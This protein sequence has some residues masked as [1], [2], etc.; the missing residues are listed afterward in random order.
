M[1]YSLNEI[2]ALVKRAARGSGLSWGL[3][4][5]A[6]M[7]TRWLA[8]F[9]LDGAYL[10]SELLNK[11]NDLSRQTPVTLDGEWFGTAG[12]LS[13]LICGPALADSAEQLKQTGEIVMQNVNH[14]A[15]LAPFAAAAAQRIKTPVSLEWQGCILVCDGA[16]LCL[17]AKDGALYTPV[18]VHVT[19]RAN[20]L[21]TAPK[22]ANLRGEISADS[23]AKLMKYAEK[24]FAPVTDI[25]RI[26]GAGAGLTDND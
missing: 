25:S 12:K 23:F 11:S 5:E 7:A 6:A 18:A 3:A 21:M 22:S 10:L 19:C 4:E 16:G 1:S 9:D 8:S 15:M 26:L 13:P 20:A 2:A 24:S 17:E 14:P